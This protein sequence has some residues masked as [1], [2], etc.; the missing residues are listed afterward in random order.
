[1]TSQPARRVASSIR[2]AHPGVLLVFGGRHAASVPTDGQEPLLVLPQ[3]LSS[4]VEAL[5]T[6]LSANG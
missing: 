6:E 2:E 5:R 1:M 4:A 3:D